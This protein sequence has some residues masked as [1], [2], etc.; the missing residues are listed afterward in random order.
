MGSAA[1]V[2]AATIARMEPPRSLTHLLQDAGWARD[3]APAERERV[4]AEMLERRVPSGGYVCRKGE[5]VDHWIGVIDGLVKM[6]NVTP[7]GKSTT[8]TGVPAG[9]WFGEGSL[10]KD[11]PRRYDI[12]AM[13]DTRVALMPRATFLR[14]LETS[15]VFNRYLLVQLNERLGQF[16]G[17]VETE[18]FHDPE[19]R[20]ARCLAMLYNPQLSPGIGARLEIS[21]E[22]IGLLAGVSRQRVNQ[23]LQALEKAGL[24]RIEYGAVAIVDLEGLR[25]FGG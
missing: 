12:V 4:A 14:L 8:F 5:A 22:E 11:E 21:Q 15:L 6:A 1:V 23:A 19:G 10:L 16:I 7:E 17:M 20:V 18:R 9:G 2:A 13:R 3:L 24:L 25:G